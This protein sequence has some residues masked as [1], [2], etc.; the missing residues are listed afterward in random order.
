MAAEEYLAFWS[1]ARLDDRDDEKLS[2]LRERLQRELQELSGHP[3]QLFQDKKNIRLG[4]DWSGKIH[5]GLQNADFLMPILTPLF[6][7]SDA[8][9]AEVAAFAQ[10]EHEGKSTDLI[11]P[12]YWI[13]SP[14]LNN[15]AR[16]SADRT[17]RIIHQHQW[18][19]WRPLRAAALDGDEVRLAITALAGKLL[20]RYEE[21]SERELEEAAISGSVTWPSEDQRVQ[22]R[23]SVAGTLTGL[24]RHTR[25]WTVVSSGHR[26]HPQCQ[27][28]P[29]T[30]GEWSGR[31]HVGSVAPNASDG[32][33]FTV[34]LAVV[35]DATNDVFE[36]Y[37]K[38]AHRPGDWDGIPPQPGY[39]I[40]M[41]RI[42][43][44]DDRIA[45]IALNGAYEEYASS[46]TGG[47]IVIRPKDGDHDFV[48]EATNAAGDIA[49]V[50]TLHV[51][52]DNSDRGAGRYGADDRHDTGRH[53]FLIDRGS[54]T[55]YVTGYSTKEQIPKPFHTV[56]KRK[57]T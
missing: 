9:R 42:L 3:H 45:Q 4:K 14:F 43:I 40:L 18:D 7:K 47:T 2:G 23:T 25:A 26:I 1:Y 39:K 44:R 35:T 16:R 52:G 36:T 57:Q 30:K 11:L 37:L 8:C 15:P 24:P 48:T 33:R 53:E 50:G 34:E 49:W 13:D 46:P 6:F 32:Q 21:L 27:A 56:W 29:G 28:K 41:R 19:D 55:I 22:R 38:E 5:E 10:R 54:G 51:D 31:I 17:A 12:I 20:E